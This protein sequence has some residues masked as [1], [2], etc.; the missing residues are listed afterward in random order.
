MKMY[1][2]VCT[3]IDGTLLDQNRQLSARTINAFRRLPENTL[4][5]LASSRMPAAMRHL[6]EELGIG[7][8]PIIAYNGGYVVRYTGDGSFRVINDEQI[9]PNVVRGIL[10]KAVPSI[11]I[12]LYHKD[13]WYVPSFDYWAER[14]ATI[15]KVNPVVASP[16]D[17]LIKWESEAKGA[18]KV[19][20]MGPE[21]DIH[22]L[23]RVLN[24]NFSGDIHVYR[25][26]P[27][28]LE[29]APAS[30]SKGK[31][32]DLLLSEDK[33]SI[34]DAVA[35]GDNYNDIELLKMCGHGIAVDN[36]LAEVQAVAA[37]ITDA[38][39]HDGVARAL[40]ELFNLV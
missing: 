21:A 24:E 32:L 11:H 22:E 40:E 19:M 8:H 3:D 23:G 13:E 7:D 5:V 39:K 30:I 35:F 2:I 14:E 6:Q 37:A 29:L 26:R 33:L 36:A 38:G 34:A 1:K 25:S 16:H 20:C 18:H 27:T 10:E 31:A 15:T 17:T 4:V 12:S 28:Y 9:P